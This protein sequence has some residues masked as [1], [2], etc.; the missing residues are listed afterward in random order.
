MSCSLIFANV[1]LAGGIEMDFAVILAPNV[2]RVLKHFAF[3][4]ITAALCQRLHLVFNTYCK[5]RLL[6]KMF[7]IAFAYNLPVSIILYI[8]I[9]PPC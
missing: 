9:K 1:N 4:V 3:V 7:Q 6:S 2:K 5:V 8:K